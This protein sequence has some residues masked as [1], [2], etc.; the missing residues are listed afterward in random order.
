M[1]VN[2][3]TR[4]FRLMPHDSINADFICPGRIKAASECVAALMWGMLHFQLVHDARP[5]LPILC[6][7]QPFPVVFKQ[8]PAF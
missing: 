7:A 4:P 3:F 2:P 5:K 6:L 8:I 1:G